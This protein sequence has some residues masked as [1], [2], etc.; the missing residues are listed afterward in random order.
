MG[1]ALIAEK[2]MEAIEKVT[3]KRVR[4]FNAKTNRFV[5][6]Q[7]WNETVANLTLMA[8]GSSAPEILLSIIELTVINDF[9]SGKLGPST[10]VGSAAFNL[11]LISAI[12]VYVIPES[13][14]RR[15]KEF[16]VYV[17]TAFFSIFAYAWLLIILKLHTPDVVEVWE[18]VFTFLFFPILVFVAY[19]ADQGAFSPVRQ[20]ECNFFDHI[21]SSHMSKEELA[22]LDQQVRATHSRGE[23]M[24]SEQVRKII[25][26][27]YT[28]KPSRAAYRVAA[29]RQLTAGRRV[30]LAGDALIRMS[31]GTGLV[32][33]MSDAKNNMINMAGLSKV[34]P[35][36]GDTQE[37]A[38]VG[39][40]KSGASVPAVVIEFQCSRKAVLENAGHVSL[41][42]IRTGDDSV[43]ASVCYQT[44]DGT[45]MKEVDYIAVSGEL[46]F[47][48]GETEKVIKVGIVDDNAYEEDENFF[49]D[50]FEPS[51]CSDLCQVAQLGSRSTMTVIIIDDDH[52]GVLQFPQDQLTVYQEIT[53]RTID[54]VVER[55]G[56]AS[57]VISCKYCTMDGSAVAGRD[58]EKA[59]GEIWFEHGV[60]TKSFPI[61][62]KGRGRYDRSEMFRIH[63][64]DAKGGAKFEPETDGGPDSCILT[65]IIDV[66]EDTK[67]SIDR[68]MNSLLSNWNKAKVGHSNWRDQF[69]DAVFV[70]GGLADDNDDEEV[71]VADPSCMDYVTHVILL[72]WKLFF[73]IVPPTDYCGGWLCFWSSLMMI[74]IVTLVV[75]ELAALLGCVV[76]VND[77]VTAI[78]I[79]ALGTS[80]PDTFA[81]KEAA[82][83]DLNADASICNVT[84]SNSVNVFL[85][86]GLPWMIGAIYWT[87]MGAP[88]G[89]EWRRRYW[90]EFGGEYPRG[91]FIVKADGLVFSVSVFSGCASVALALFQIRRSFC[92]GE[93]GGPRKAKIVSSVFLATLW[94]VYI[95]CSVVYIER[96]N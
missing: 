62:V 94:V 8:L 49:V 23:S 54:V 81:S 10:I 5:T 42:V 22:A 76:G 79:V 70:N 1:V 66:H 88:E 61:V 28:Q 25:E 96:D 17:V 36:D 39:C 86:L 78:T 71:V 12:C 46:V 82:L 27:N 11:F 90:D 34:A 26:I 69:F 55:R 89:S 65:V 21:V 7:V 95:A 40:D 50:L 73:A 75:G 64:Q 74:G 60:L 24:T 4:K 77:E 37:A 32:K 6:V 20:T 58:F 91:A 19:M 14:S 57:G 93:L 33:R 3:A 29:T 15:I 52:P 56:G 45:A 67:H 85:G 92:D 59:H 41:P 83:K 48:P 44:R 87:V 68:M 43:V 80:L 63:L 13:E 51:C 53:D 30:K 84:G 16:P 35:I 31:G 72:P 2:F 9:Y 47:M 38:T 18:G